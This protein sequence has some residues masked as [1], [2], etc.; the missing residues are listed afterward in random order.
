MEDTSS[1]PTAGSAGDLLLAHCRQCGSYTFPAA[2]YGCR[3][4]GA[5]GD[6]L[7]AVTPPQPVRLLNFVTIHAEL[8]PGLP[9]PYVAGE[10]ELAPGV[11]EEALIEAPDEQGLRPGM[12]VQPRRHGADEAAGWRFVPVEGAA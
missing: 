2:A 7:R 9:V 1:T 11:V 5:T 4:C 3:Q 10:V 12:V 6:A 8:A